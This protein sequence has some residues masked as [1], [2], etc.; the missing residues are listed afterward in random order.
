MAD[1]PRCASVDAGLL[2]LRLGV[3]AVL[4]CSGLEKLLAGWSGLEAV[5]RGMTCFGVNS[6]FAA[7]G[8]LAALVESLGGVLVMLG[9]L[10][11]PAALGLAL[12]MAAVVVKHLRSASLSERQFCVWSHALLI[13]LVALALL[14]T[15]A[16]GFRAKFKRKVK[17]APQPEPQ[18]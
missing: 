14:I 2:V 15:G 10:F 3:G 4:I 1:S 8:L 7:W 9:L 18:T 16:G 13:G 5:G 12:A 11:R 17:A 6:G